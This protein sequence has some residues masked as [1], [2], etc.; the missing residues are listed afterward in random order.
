MEMVVWLIH[1]VLL[2]GQDCDKYIVMF[3][4]CEDDS[5]AVP[6]TKTKTHLA[7]IWNVT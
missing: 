1:V 6:N 4:A 3:V 2:C 5:S 7:T